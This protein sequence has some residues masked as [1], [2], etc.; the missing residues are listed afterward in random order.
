[1]DLMLPSGIPTHQ[2]NVTKWWMWLDQVFLSDHS[3]DVLISCDTQAQWRGINTDHLPIITAL[4]LMLAEVP[5]TMTR[6]FRDVDWERFREKLEAHLVKLGV[7][8]WINNQTQLDNAC[9]KV[10]LAIQ[11]TI[12]AEVPT[13]SISP[14]TKHW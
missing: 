12:A 10:M 9:E 2:H 4:N 3:I 14:K 1:M 11:D 6:N 7:P 5:T 13:T 8:N